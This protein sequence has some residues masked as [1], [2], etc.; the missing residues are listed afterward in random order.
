MR[1]AG[2]A[3]QNYFGQLTIQPPNPGG[4]PLT[5]FQAN[6]SLAFSTGANG[7]VTVS[8]PV[9]GV[10]LSIT[11]VAGAQTLVATNGGAGLGIQS[12]GTSP[13]MS[14]LDN[15]ANGVF[16]VMQA[17]N[18]GWSV[19]FGWNTSA[20]SGNAAFQINGTGALVIKQTSG[21]Y[22]G[23]NMQT[24]AV[25]ATT[26]T[27]NNNA[28]VV[29]AFNNSTGATAVSG[30]TF[31]SAAN[32]NLSA[33]IAGQAATATSGQLLLQYVTGSALTTGATITQFGEFF[34]SAPTSGHVAL[35]VNGV[36]GTHSAKISDSAA[37][38]HNAGFLEINQNS[39]SANYTTVL[40]DSGKHIY[41]PSADTTARTWTI[42][43]NANVP[44]PIGTAITFDND[45]SAGVITLAIT[46]DTLVWLP[47]GTTGSRTI[48]A[49]GQAT[50]LKVTATRWHITGVGIT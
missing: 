25:A 36:S 27:V 29:A 46:T 16:A 33:G 50:A 4:N 1:V 48:A 21:S 15:G 41:H 11:G 37:V 2:N 13:V 28:S 30:I 26:L 19:N 12:T 22:S 39:Q 45:T 38:L 44:Y 20:P 6:G 35:T 7:N 10:A 17:I 47:S 49:N 9:S 14:I 3:I 24:P 5:V 34:V 18:T 23:I 32:S 31:G 40:S 8:A 43:S 42:D